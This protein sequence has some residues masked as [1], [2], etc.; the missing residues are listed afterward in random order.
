MALGMTGSK[1][2]L[3]ETNPKEGP[4]ALIMSPMVSPTA[5]SR[6]KLHVRSPVVRGESMEILLDELGS[7]CPFFKIQQSTY[8]VAPGFVA[9]A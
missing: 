4:L 8:P 7:G 1:S 3:K 2:G 5:R 9:P 6:I